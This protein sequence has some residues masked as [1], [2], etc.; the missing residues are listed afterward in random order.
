MKKLLK[1][2][3]SGLL[4]HYKVSYTN[5]SKLTYSIPTFT[6]IE[7]LLGAILGFDKWDYH[8]KINRENLYIGIKVNN[9]IDKLMLTLNQID[10]INPIPKKDNKEE[11]GLIKERNQI[12]MEHIFKPSYTFY[13]YYKNNPNIYN[14]LLRNVLNRKS[15][16]PLYFGSAYCLAQ[17]EEVKE[18]NFEEKEINDNYENILTVLPFD[19]NIDIK[20]HGKKLFILQENI[21]YIRDIDFTMKEYKKV[22]FNPLGDNNGI[23]CKGNFY[24]TEDDE[25]IYLFGNQN[26]KIS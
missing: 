17:F 25:L 14:D 3:L 9:R 13:I 20:I 8:I 23:E 12:Q 16:Y 18:I 15:V 26:D 24:K 7:G 1:F 19:K 10:F 4:A 6:S 21:P 2:S 11:Y 5:T 22:I